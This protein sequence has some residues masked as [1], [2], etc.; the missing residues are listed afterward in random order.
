MEGNPITIVWSFP[1][2]YD[3]IKC[4][5]GWGKAWKEVAE[6]R[7]GVSG[8]CTLAESEARTKPSA[9]IKLAYILNTGRVQTIDTLPNQ[10]RSDEATPT[11]YNCNAWY[12]I[13]RLQATRFVTLKSPSLFHFSF[14]LSCVWF[15][16][17]ISKI[18]KDCPARFCFTLHY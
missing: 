15:E 16:K 4:V 5:W 11:N 9:Q 13:T 17:F 7:V 14:R 18:P 12:T 2:I 1:V 3:L 10:N 8:E 6:M